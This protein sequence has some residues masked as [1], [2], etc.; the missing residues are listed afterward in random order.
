MAS[1]RKASALAPVDATA[2]CMIG[3]VYEKLGQPDKAMQTY[4]RAM[5]VKPG[6][7]LA[8]Q[9]MAAIEK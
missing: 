2:I 1:F 3:Y 9:L 7:D 8:S 6:D 5:K 4:A